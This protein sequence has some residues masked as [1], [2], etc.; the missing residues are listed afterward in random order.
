M[1]KETV[2]NRRYVE[3]LNEEI[4]RGLARPEVAERMRRDGM[5]VDPMTPEQY[6]AFI[7]R[8]TK[9]W[10]PV[11]KEAGLTVEKDKK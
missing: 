9:V 3:L 8:E 5:I 11:M 6:A 2:P 1:Q 10:A 4:Q 7:E